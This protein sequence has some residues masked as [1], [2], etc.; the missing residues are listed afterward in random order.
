[1][2]SANGTRAASASIITSTPASI[3]TAFPIAS[4]APM[5]TCG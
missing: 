1:M 2:N 4:C 3:I 5:S